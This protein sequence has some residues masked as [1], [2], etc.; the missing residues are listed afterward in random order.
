VRRILVVGA[1][2]AGATYARVLA[3]AGCAVTIIDRRPHVAGNAYDE[4]D[5]TGTR[6]H[7]Y[8]PHFFHTSNPRVVD[9]VQ[10][11]G[12]WTPY[13]LRVR[14]LAGSAQYLPLPINRRTIE[15][16]HG[17]VL[18]SSEETEQFLRSVST[19]I[20]RI[21]TA[22][23]FLFAHVGP[24]ITNLLFRPYTRKMWALD[25]DQLSASVVK[26][27]PIRYDCTD[28]YFPD[29][30]FQALPT[31]GYSALFHS[32]LDHDLIEVHCGEV[33]E[34]AARR[35]YDCTFTSAAIDDHFD[36][37][38]GELP[39]RSIRFVDEIR[40]RGEPSAWPIT[41]F[42][43][44]EGATR[45]TNWSALPHHD[46]GGKDRTVTRE[47]PCDYKENGYERYYPVKTADDR[48]GDIYRRYKARADEDETLFFIGRCGTYQYLDMHQVINQSLLGAEQWLRGLH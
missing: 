38:Y 11:F 36:Y 14:A 39:Y 42:T 43:D 15:A 46:G 22:E 28:L 27:L 7:R 40:P 20:E 8:G 33:F 26:R 29:D 10:R 45:E 35:D 44:N 3:E 23:D 12:A 1:G 6:I 48:Y 4:T 17:V 5:A 32:I 19:P 30:T 41:N 16:V 9:W 31:A 25:L 21:E 24:A 18:S 2:F 37:C 47:Y 34:H 13:Q